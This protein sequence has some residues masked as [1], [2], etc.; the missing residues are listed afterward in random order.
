MG[1][2]EGWPGQRHRGREDSWYL[3]ERLRPYGGAQTAIQGLLDAAQQ[4]SDAEES[5]L[6]VT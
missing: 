3:G 4:A 5:L 6:S 1:R 2:A